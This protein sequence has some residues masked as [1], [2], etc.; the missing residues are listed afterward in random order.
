MTTETCDRRVVR[1]RLSRAKYSHDGTPSPE[2][3]LRAGRT[4]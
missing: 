4:T 1:A 2:E 3:Y